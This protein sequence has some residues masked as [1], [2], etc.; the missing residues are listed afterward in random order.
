M[1][2]YAQKKEKKEPKLQMCVCG[3]GEGDRPQNASIVICLA[4]VMRKS[5]HSSFSSSCFFELKFISNFLGCFPSL[6]SPLSLPT[7]TILSCVL[8]F[9][10]HTSCF[11]LSL[12]FR[13]SMKLFQILTKC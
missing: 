5:D 6:L 1:G 13:K 9:F 7:P 8:F 3:G 11:A 12:T 2:E 4:R 10:F